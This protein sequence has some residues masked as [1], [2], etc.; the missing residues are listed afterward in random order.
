MTDANSVPQ[1]SEIRRNVLSFEP[2]WQDRLKAM[3]QHLDIRKNRIRERTRDM[4]RS[5]DPSRVATRSDRLP[6]G[7]GR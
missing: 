2:D 6:P 5:L 7:L 3:E 4:A 1:L